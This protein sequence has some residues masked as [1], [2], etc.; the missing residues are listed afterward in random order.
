M[1]KFIKFTGV[2]AVFSSL[3]ACG[4]APGS[5]DYSGNEAEVMASG[6]SS[7]GGFS[8]SSSSSS[9]GAALEESSSSSSSSGSSSSSSGGPLSPTAL[10]DCLSVR[11]GLSYDT[12]TTISEWKTVAGSNNPRVTSEQIQ[13]STTADSFLGQPAVL[14]TTYRSGVEEDASYYAP[15]H[16]GDENVTYLGSKHISSG[17]DIRFNAYLNFIYPTSL[18]PGQAFRNVARG[19]LYLTSGVTPIDESEYSLAEPY[20]VNYVGQEALQMESSNLSFPLTCKFVDVYVN[21]NYELTRQVQPR[22]FINTDK[23]RTITRWYVPGRGLVK[24][25]THLFVAE[26]S[27]PEIEDEIQI[28]SV[29]EVL[30]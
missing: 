14:V 13:V 24:Q 10:N 29:Y 5:S 25:V 19:A 16:E 27:S 30:Q 11:P 1:N 21:P 8:S 26:R 23:K 28:H 3:V 18:E 12:K 9:G 7:S 22:V 6:S 17:G 2:A 20:V 15:Y 4:V